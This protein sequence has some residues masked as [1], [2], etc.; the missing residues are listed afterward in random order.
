VIGPCGCIEKTADLLGIGWDAVQ[1]IM[2]RGVERGLE[3]RKLEKIDYVGIDEKS[4]KKGQSYVSLINDLKGGR[5]L[6]VVKDRTTQSTD[7]LWLTLEEPVRKQ[8]KA[9]ALDMWDPFIKSTW[10]NAPAALV[11]HDRFHISSYLGKAVDQVRRSEHKELMSAGDD[12][13][14]G[15][16]QLWLFNPENLTDAR[17]MEFEKLLEMDLKCAQAWSM[18]ENLRHLWDYT[19]GGNAKKFFGHWLEWVRESGEAPMKKVAEMLSRHLPERLNDFVHRITNAVS[20]GLNSKIQSIKLMARGFR[21]FKN[22]RVRIL[23]FCGKLDM[24]PTS[25]IH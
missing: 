7:E 13:L 23:F 8:I 22:Y 20:E 10:K 3:R 21:G 12:T 5:V 24:A 16:R 1:S 14:K 19:Y 11:V 15:R 17:W 25:S 6:E 9:V 18:K 2:E 4:F